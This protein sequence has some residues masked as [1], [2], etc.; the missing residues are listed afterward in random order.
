MIDNIFVN[1]CGV[2]IDVT[3]DVWVEE[4]MK[5]FVEVFVI[6]NVWADVG[7]DTLTDV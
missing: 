2:I 1:L 7:I 5:V 3:D 4:I 6:I